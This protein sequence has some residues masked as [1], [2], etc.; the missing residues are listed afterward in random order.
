MRKQHRTFRGDLTSTWM[1]VIGICVRLF[2]AS[3]RLRKIL[4]SGFG[5]HF[6]LLVGWV[7]IIQCIILMPTMIFRFP[8]ADIL[9]LASTLGALIGFF[10]VVHATKPKSLFG[11]SLCEPNKQ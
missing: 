5:K 8:G 10:M 3:S 1:L 9:D 4:D 11:F 2:G 6:S 7:L